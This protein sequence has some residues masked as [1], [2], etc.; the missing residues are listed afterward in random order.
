LSVI[1]KIVSEFDWT[2]KVESD[3]DKWFRIK[4]YF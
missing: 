4:I 1:D 2:M 3:T